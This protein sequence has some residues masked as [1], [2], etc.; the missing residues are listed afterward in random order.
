VIY[1]PVFLMP[2]LIYQL[3]IFL[4]IFAPLSFGA[5][6]EWSFLIIST[7]TLSGF[8]LL[9]LEYWKKK[10]VAYQ[11][12]GTVTLALFLFWIAIQIIPFPVFFVEI[13]SPFTVKLYKETIG[14]AEPVQWISLS[15]NRRS[16]LLEFFRYSTYVFFYILTVQLL[17]RKE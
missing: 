6:E 5:R 4:L 11:T 2:N 17:T 8:L 7:T 16:T 13:I 10:N 15:I 3:F 12:P 1:F 14:I 9:L